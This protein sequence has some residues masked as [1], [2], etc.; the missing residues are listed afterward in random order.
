MGLKFFNNQHCWLL[1][2]RN[3][4]QDWKLI[5]RSD[6]RSRYVTFVRIA[7][8]HLQQLRSSNQLQSEQDRGVKVEEVNEEKNEA[9][10][11]QV[12][13]RVSERLSADSG[14]VSPSGDEHGNGIAPSTDRGSDYDHDGKRIAKEIKV[15]KSDLHP[16]CT[17]ETWSHIVDTFTKAFCIGDVGDFMVIQCLGCAVLVTFCLICIFW[18]FYVR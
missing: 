9:V 12:K 5:Q 4:L 14:V 16:Y 11:G 3:R 1:A 2:S 17:C 18:I 8:Y 13:D 7:A 10:Q 15:S 6:F